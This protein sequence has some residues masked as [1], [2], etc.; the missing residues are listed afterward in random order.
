MVKFLGAN[1]RGNCVDPQC[2]YRDDPHHHVNLS[3]R[4]RRAEAA[5]QRRAAKVGAP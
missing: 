3:R 4:E 5:R 2:Q 1:E